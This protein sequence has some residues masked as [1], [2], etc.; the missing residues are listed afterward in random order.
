MF[1]SGSDGFTEPYRAQFFIFSVGFRCRRPARDDAH[2]LSECVGVVAGGV[3]V[4]NCTIVVV[5]ARSWCTSTVSGADGG[6][7][8]CFVP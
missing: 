8:V 2:T 5:V 3:V 4:V 1:H 7:G 6:V